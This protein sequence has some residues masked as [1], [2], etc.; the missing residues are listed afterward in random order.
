MKLQGIQFVKLNPIAGLLVATAVLAGCSAGGGSATKTTGTTTPTAADLVVTVDKSSIQDTGSDTA[1]ITV[2]A[3][4]SN[5][6]VVASAPI[7]ITPNASSNAIVTPSGTE[8]STAGIVTGALSIGSDHTNRTINVVVT[9]GSITK[10]LAVTVTGAKLTANAVSGSSGSTATI[11]YHLADA[12]GTN[13]ASVPISVSGD[14]LPTVNDKTDSNGNYTYTYTVPSTASLVISATAGGVTTATTV[15]VSASTTPA[16]SGTPSAESIAANPNFVNVNSASSTA[17]QIQVRALFQDSNNVPISNVR[18]RFDLD[19]DV[20]SIGGT[21]SSGANYVYTDANGIATT[22]YI[23]GTRGSGSNALTIRACWSTTDF[24]AGTCPNPTPLTTTVTVIQG[25][26]SVSKPFTDNIIGV[27]N[28][29]LVYTLPF[30]VQV[31]DSVGNPQSGIKVTATSFIPRYY[32]GSWGF[33][34]VL[35]NGVSTTAYVPDV[36]NVCDNEDVNHNNVLDSGEDINLSGKLEPASSD[37]AIVPT[38]AGSDTTDASGL[39]YFT[40]QYGQNLASW[41]DYYLTFTAV[42]QGTEGSN[43]TA[44][45]LPVPN[46]AITSAATATP[47]FQDSPYNLLP[48]GEDTA[49][50]VNL[51]PVTNNATPPVT[52]HLCQKQL[53]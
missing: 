38:S 11:V 47:P 30:S 5:R 52:Y 24:T 31:T 27:D 7:T 51:T 50:P 25:G 10:N 35:Q 26:V 8:T 23:A 48:P 46:A 13:L 6:N 3:V 29:R 17:N 45:N 22:T 37:V 21:L 9:S 36:V 19:G 32:R 20:N 12:A 28:T 16:A 53:T 49:Y 40:M 4:D 41:E 1:T 18:V 42:V 39:A 43:Y 33:A 44:G 2:T 15:T 14:S 34:T